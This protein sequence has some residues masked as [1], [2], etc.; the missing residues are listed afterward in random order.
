[1]A[2]VYKPTMQLL[3]AGR[4]LSG[5]A[6]GDVMQ[7]L[8]NG[9]LEPVQCAAL[10]TSLAH[11]GVTATELTA[12]A[13]AMRDAAVA[14]P[15]ARD[16]IDT[17]GTGGSGLDTI[18]TST[19][20]AFVL[21]AAGVRV[22]KHGNRSSSGQCGS[23]DVLE[24]LGVE[25]VVDATRATTSLNRTG[26]AFLFSPAFHPAM[27]HV[28]PV[29]RAL[30]FRT[31]FNF[32]GPLCNPARPKRQVI[33]VSDARMA[34]TMAHALAGLGVD[35]AIVAHG[36]DGLDELSSC[37]ATDLWH[38]RESKVTRERC[39]PE[40]L[41]IKRVPAAA[42]RGGN[43]VTNKALFEAVLVGAAG[44]AYTEHVALNA[45]AGLFVTERAASIAQGVAIARELLADGSA[46]R[47]FDRFAAENPAESRAA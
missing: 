44:P 46:K 12:F 35:R 36:L 41:G 6:A 23:A 10:L 42:I 30:G 20:V 32:L 9:A 1:M 17:C 29:R 8:M 28:V 37:A 4:D 24:A 43:G 13:T 38:V 45:G 27:R 19:L 39:E 7:A 2:D 26:V 22:A 25:L 15:D 34:D 16:S 40:S 14:V 3:L 18:N 11:K 47:A 5:G 31:V 21:A 33:G